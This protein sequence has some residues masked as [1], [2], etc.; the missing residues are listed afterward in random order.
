M[1]HG[2]GQHAWDISLAEIQQ[3]YNVSPFCLFIYI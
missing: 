2:W 3:Y 1:A